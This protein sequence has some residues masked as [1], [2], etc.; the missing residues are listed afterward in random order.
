MYAQGEDVEESVAQKYFAYKSPSRHTK[1]FA[2]VR[3]PPDG[4]YLLVHLYVNP[5]TVPLEADF[6]R[7]YREVKTNCAWLEVTVRTEDD[8]SRI[9]GL[10]ASSF[11]NV[12]LP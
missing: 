11:A 4:E 10:V 5:N 7:D 3:I 8:I 1:Q 2:R 9:T 12:R 6:T